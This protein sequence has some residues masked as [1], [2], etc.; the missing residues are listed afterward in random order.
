MNEPARFFATDLPQ[1]EQTRLAVV[2]LP[3]LGVEEEEEFALSADLLWALEL[4]LPWYP[5]LAL[6]H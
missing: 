4:A 3:L 6:L 1:L 2:S 5:E